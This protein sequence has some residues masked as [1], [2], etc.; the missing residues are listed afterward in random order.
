MC[1]QATG[2]GLGFEMLSTLER[3]A[4][5]QEVARMQLSVLVTNTNAL[6]LYKKLGYVIEGERR[7]TVKL[8]SGYVNEYVMGKWIADES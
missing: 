4:K 1:R 3:W 6:K 7:G 2:K 5:I 8:S